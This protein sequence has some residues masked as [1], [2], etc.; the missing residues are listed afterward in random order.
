[1]KDEKNIL[2]SQS[3]AVDKHCVNLGTLM[4]ALFYDL[5]TEKDLKIPTQPEKRER[6]LVEVIAKRRK[7]IVLFVDEAHDLHHK[8]LHTGRVFEQQRWALYSETPDWAAVGITTPCGAPCGSS[9]RTLATTLPSSQTDN[10][11]SSPIRAVAAHRLGTG[12]GASPSA[13][14]A[15]AAWDIRFD[16]QAGVAYVPRARCGHPLAKD[17]W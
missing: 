4:T 2:V 15:A 17:R 9:T 3:L 13:G 16:A 11:V 12:E 5:V 8:P 1:M 6:K 7:S 14:I 10:E